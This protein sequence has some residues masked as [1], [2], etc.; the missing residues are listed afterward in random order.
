[1]TLS[2]DICLQHAHIN[3]YL[4]KAPAQATKQWSWPTTKYRQSGLGPQ[5]ARLLVLQPARQPH[6]HLPRCWLSFCLSLA[7]SHLSNLSLDLLGDK[8]HRR[9]RAWVEKQCL[10]PLTLTPT[11]TTLGW[12][13]MPSL[14]GFVISPARPHQAS[15]GDL[16]SAPRSYMAHLKHG[17]VANHTW[18]MGETTFLVVSSANSLTDLAEGSEEV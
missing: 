2:R 11:P 12:L 3:R 6:E 13:A 5:Y 17:H 10:V 16:A 4:S 9:R 7:M 8:A 18:C 15:M 14:R 1:M